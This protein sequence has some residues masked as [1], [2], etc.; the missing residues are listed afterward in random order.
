MATASAI[1]DAR[2]GVIAVLRQPGLHDADG[3]S[4][5]L[6]DGQQLVPVGRRDDIAGPGVEFFDNEAV[7]E[8]ESLPAESKGCPRVE[9]S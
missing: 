6:L 8:N 5:D 4:T 2:L 9:T 1:G 7:D 3:V